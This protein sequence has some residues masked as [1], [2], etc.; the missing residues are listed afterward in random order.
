MAR[1]LGFIDPSPPQGETYWC[2]PA[3]VVCA[4]RALGLQPPVGLEKWPS[5]EEELGRLLECFK[6]HNFKRGAG[7]KPVAMLARR[8]GLSATPSA[9]A[10]KSLGEVVISRMAT[11]AA[12]ILQWKPKARAYGKAHWGLIVEWSDAGV[13]EITDSYMSK[14]FA[15]V[16]RMPVTE[17][18]TGPRP[19]IVVVR[20]H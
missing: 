2:G 4:A 16:R 13:I 19:P 1:L 18:T 20:A 12:V 15:D 5:T 10:R 3:S 6:G 8:L 11:G 7:R 14:H 9:V 17:L